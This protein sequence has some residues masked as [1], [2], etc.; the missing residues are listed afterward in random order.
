MYVTTKMKIKTSF[1]GSFTKGM[2]NIAGCEI[3]LVQGRV[4]VV[5]ATLSKHFHLAISVYK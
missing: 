4:L 2:V 1:C 3:S 5:R